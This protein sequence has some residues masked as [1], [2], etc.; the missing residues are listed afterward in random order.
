LKTNGGSNGSSSSTYV[1]NRGRGGRGRG[2]GRGGRGRNNPG[3]GQE[4]HGQQPHN[5]K[6]ERCQ[7][8]FKKGHAANECWHRFDENYV[9]DEKLVGAAYNSYDVDTNWYTDT[10]ASDHI[11]SNLEKLSVRDKYKGND[12]I[13]TASGAGMKISHIGHTVVPTSSK[14]LHLNNILHVPDAAKN[15]ISVHRLAQDNSVFF[16]FHPDYFLIKDQATKNTILRGEATRLF[17]LF[18]QPT[19]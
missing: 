6:Q 9:P 16:E 17:I 5:N 2:G 7:V 19:Q 3:R 11:T 18:L 10:G 4:G 13:H 14:H 15:L 12:Q 1:A 8:C